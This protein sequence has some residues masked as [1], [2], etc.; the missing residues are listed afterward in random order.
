MIRFNYSYIEES[1]LQYFGNEGFVK[2]QTDQSRKE[3]VQFIGKIIPIIEYRDVMLCLRDIV[4]SNYDIKSK[5]REEYFKWLNNELDRQVSNTITTKITKLN[6]ELITINENLETLLPERNRLK[7]NIRGGFPDGFNRYIWEFKS[8][9]R[10]KNI[11]ALYFLLDPVISVHPDTVIFE[12]LSLDESSY[13]NLSIPMDQFIVEGKTS[14]GT[15]NIDFSKKLSDE[16]SQ[17]RSDS[18]LNLEI[19][20]GGLTVETASKPAYIEKK[21]DLPE[22]WVKGFLQ[23]SSALAFKSL[24]ITITP[25]DL[26]T[27][28]GFL[29][30]HRAHRSP[31]ALRFDLIPN[32]N[33]F[34]I[35]E[36][37]NTVLKLEGK[38]TGSKP[39]TIRIW[40]RRRILLLERIIPHA[41]KIKIRLIGK[42][43]P[44][45]FQVELKNMIFTL[46]LS[47]WTKNNWS[48][49]IAFSSILGSGLH[50]DNNIIE[51]LQE[52]RNSN[53][54]DLKLQFNKKRENVIN[55][56]LAYLYRN[57]KA[58]Y[59]INSD[60]VRYR[61]LAPKPFPKTVTNL[62]PTEL[63][64]LYALKNLLNFQITTDKAKNLNIESKFRGNYWPTILKLTDEGIYISS[65]CRCSGSRK[66]RHH[67]II[68]PHILALYSKVLKNIE[69]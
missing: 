61:E 36:P 9:I 26:Y 49:G 59:D 8:F 63:Q 62:S 48:Q 56:T 7:K 41:K 51:Y 38:Y 35:F 23:V 54:E 42:G 69:S 2:L 20:P 58:F 5:E 43:M 55:D 30:G 57:G 3:K 52:F 16:F 37:W 60:T 33:I 34:A 65:N 19:N 47:G 1:S 32:N 64:A 14:F 44:L 45:F 15:T 17:I 40:G 29:K 66:G 53:M 21:I 6:N 68:C 28:I 22:S 18:E 31:R 67:K 4:K 50:Y 25:N 46:G 27:L 39:A 24:E 10:E 13:A 11:T 12:A